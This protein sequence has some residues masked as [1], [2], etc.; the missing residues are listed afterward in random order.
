MHH[1]CVRS[2]HKNYVQ[3]YLVKRM[4][5]VMSKICTCCVTKLSYKKLVWK[6]ICNSYKYRRSY[7]EK[8][9][10]S[11]YVEKISHDSYWKKLY[12]YVIIN[13]VKV[14]I[15]EDRNLP[16]KEDHQLS[17]IECCLLAHALIRC[18]LSPQ[19]S[20]SKSPKS[21]A[22]NPELQ[23]ANSKPLYP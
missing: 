2:F 6:I 16:R 3:S 19:P 20:P 17:E 12:T 9:S 8:I 21:Q 5:K 11:S 7:T 18:T 10:F 23:F 22:L 4:K 14:E 15:Y 1:S 13:F